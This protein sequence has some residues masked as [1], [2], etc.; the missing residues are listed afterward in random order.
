MRVKLFL[1]WLSPA[2]LLAAVGVGLTF[3]ILLLL[4]HDWLLG[5]LWA[6]LAFGIAAVTWAALHEGER[7][8]R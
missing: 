7:R 3:L 6:G 8:G 1:N 2:L 4:G 5:K